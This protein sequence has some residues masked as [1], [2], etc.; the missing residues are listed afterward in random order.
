MSEPP[1]PQFESSAENDD[2][3]PNCSGQWAAGATGGL[4]SSSDEV[5]RVVAR[6]PAP[7]EDEG[8]RSVLVAGATALTVAARAKRELTDPI[9]FLA[10]QYPG[11]RLWRFVQRILRRGRAGGCRR[12]MR[13][14]AANYVDNVLKGAK[15]C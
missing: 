12:R 2:D 8:L 13:R 3:W 5:R 11:E 4:R 15:A 7:P 10:S 6:D 9:E 14:A 1:R